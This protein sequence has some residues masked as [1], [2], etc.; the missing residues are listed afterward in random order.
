MDESIVLNVLISLRFSSL[1]TALRTL[2]HE[3]GHA[4]HFANITQASPLFSQERAPTSVAYAE[5]QSMFLDSLIQDAAWRAK[6][7][8][9]NATPIPFALHEEEIRATH[10]FAVLD[11]RAMLSVSYLEKA[12]YELPPD[13]VTATKIQALA[14][15]IERDIQGGLGSRPLLSVPHLVSDEASCYYQGYTLVRCVQSSVVGTSRFFPIFSYVVALLSLCLSWKLQAE[16]S[17][18]QTREFFKKRDG[19]IVDN[20]LVGST[21][22]DAYWKCG[23]SRPFLEIVKDLTGKE[24]SGDDWVNSL[25]ESV[26]E[27]VAR[28]R[29]EYDE[30]LKK[31][32]A[33]SE[34]ESDEIDLDMTVKFVDGDQ[35]IADSSKGGIIQACKEFEAFVAKRVAVSS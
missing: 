13:Q 25:N 31:V 7:A 18:Y 19:Y 11:L 12:I 15:E 33:S 24:L 10:P 8:C 21:L 20:P 6:Y 16:M 14:D 32:A 22:A 34:K 28:E 3:A 1:D 2:M 26:D 29:K 5:N 4:A 9:N 23:N 17:V 27:K 35:L 30:M